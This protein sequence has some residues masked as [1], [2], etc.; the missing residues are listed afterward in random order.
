MLLGDINIAPKPWDVYWDTQEKPNLVSHH[1]LEL[2]RFDQL[3]QWGLT[4]LGETLLEPRDYTFFDYRFFWDY[5][6]RRYRY[7]IGL[8]IDHFLVTK[9]LVSRGLS[10]E[11]LRTWRHK[12]KGNKPSDQVPVL[13]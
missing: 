5:K 1:P 4:D 10:M 13:L 11:V 12:K 2:A 7:D 6:A 9:S 8:R 3:L